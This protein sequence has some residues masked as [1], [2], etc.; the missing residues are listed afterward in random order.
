[1]SEVL[2]IVTFF[3]LVVFAIGVCVRSKNEGQD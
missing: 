2:Q 1:M 3:G